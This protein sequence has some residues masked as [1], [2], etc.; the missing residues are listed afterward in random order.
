[1]MALIPVKGVAKAKAIC[2]VLV[3]VLNV[4]GAAR[5]PV[6]VLNAN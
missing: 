3:V 1:M 2:A 4:T 5:P 6:K